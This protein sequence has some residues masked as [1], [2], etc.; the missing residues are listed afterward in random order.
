MAAKRDSKDPMPTA[1][2][3]R[4]VGKDGGG[5]TPVSGEKHGSKKADRVGEGSRFSLRS[6]NESQPTRQKGDGNTSVSGEKH[7]SKKAEHVP[8]SSRF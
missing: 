5:N 4:R 3:S 1:D 6:G 8:A 2:N 7:G